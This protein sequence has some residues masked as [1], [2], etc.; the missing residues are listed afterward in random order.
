MA[1]HKH[2]QQSQLVATVPGVGPIGAVSFAL[3]RC[4]GAS[5]ENKA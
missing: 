5:G 3:K 2:N 1:W 4:Y